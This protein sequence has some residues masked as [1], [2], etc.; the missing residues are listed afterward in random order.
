[1]TGD[2]QNGIYPTKF[3]TDVPLKMS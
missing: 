2:I 3:T 1:V